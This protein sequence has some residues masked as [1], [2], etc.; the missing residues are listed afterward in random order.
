MPKAWRETELE[1]EGLTLKGEGTELNSSGGLRNAA[2]FQYTGFVTD[3]N[4]M[5]Q[6]PIDRANAAVV[7]ADTSLS[8]TSQG[9]NGGSDLQIADSEALAST[10]H[11]RAI[12]SSIMRDRQRLGQAPPPPLN[13]VTQFEDL[14]SRRLL[15]RQPELLDSAP[16]VQADMTPG[17]G[18]TPRTPG[19][20]HPGDGSSQG[21]SAG[22][23]ANP[24]E[25]A[26]A[27]QVDSVDSVESV[28]FHRNYIETTCLSLAS[29]SSA[30]WA[31]VCILLDPDGVV[32]LKTIG[33][34]AILTQGEL[35]EKPSTPRPVQTALTRAE[36]SRGQVLPNNGVSFLDLAERV[37]TKCNNALLIGFRRDSGVE[38]NP[39]DKGVGLT[40][41]S[42]D[43]LIVLQPQS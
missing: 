26:P 8:D 5:K 17:H 3:G 18:M 6:L 41:C 23:A 13:L 19:S 2:L 10:I 31:A 38:L 20:S 16:V 42:N 36:L 25:V 15:E 27:E 28:G 32:Q 1:A 37:R 35:S 43:Q 39:P 4:A 11:L 22:S 40:W 14:L 21:A 34:S 9:G 30:S 29:Q 7:Q 33:A 12:H 24:G